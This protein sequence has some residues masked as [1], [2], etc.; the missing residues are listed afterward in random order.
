[1]RK[2]LYLL[3]AGVAFFVAGRWVFHQ[4]STP[5]PV[6]ASQPIQPFT[7]GQDI[8]TFK[9]LATGE[10]ASRR[11]VARRSDGT[12]A[13]IDVVKAGDSGEF[14]VLRKV[15]F[16]DG[17]A[18]TLIESINSKLSGFVDRRRLDRRLQRMTSPPTD[19]IQGPEKVV[20]RET[21]YGHEF[22]VLEGS[23]D[24][25]KRRSW[26]SPALGCAV[27]QMIQEE[28]DAAGKWNRTTQVV[29]NRL[30]KGEPDP[31]FFVAGEKFKEMTPTEAY[32][33][34]ARQKGIDPDACAKCKE[35][36][37]EL[38]K[39]YWSKQAPSTTGVK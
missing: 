2:A 37:W 17:S 26:Q 14:Q 20:A 30:T 5:D 13:E 27:M 18:M 15:E 39:A 25:A 6:R 16:A 33:E 31:Q 11:T 36:I 19:C 22:L 32:L 28:K 23:D 7:M 34:A 21:L 3:V 29:L 38:E 10:L 4:F 9:R 12:E 35:S 1:M 24:R 8:Y